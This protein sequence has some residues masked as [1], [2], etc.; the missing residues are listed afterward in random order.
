[1]DVTD[2]WTGGERGAWGSAVRWLVGAG[3]RAFAWVGPGD[4]LFGFCDDGA[5]S[6]SAPATKAILST[7][8]G[9]RSD[10]GAGLFFLHNSS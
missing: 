4:F 9:R 1:M 8:D 6:S 3:F 7:G 5:I 10:V 2:V